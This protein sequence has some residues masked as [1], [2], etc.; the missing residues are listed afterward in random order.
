MIIVDCIEIWPT[1]GPAANANSPFPICTCIENPCRLLIFFAALSSGMEYLGHIKRLWI[2]RK[3]LKKGDGWDQGKR[4]G[5]IEYRRRGYHRKS[6][7]S[8]SLL[9]ISITGF[10]IKLKGTERPGLYFYFSPKKK[11][12]LA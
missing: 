12:L 3:E 10:I 9:V 6:L 8:N 5:I 1:N 2:E 4:V 7:S 11:T